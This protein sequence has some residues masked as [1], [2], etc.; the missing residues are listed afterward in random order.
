MSFIS[1][2]TKPSTAWLISNTL[3]LANYLYMASYPTK[4]LNIMFAGQP[5]IHKTLKLLMNCINDSNTTMPEKKLI[6]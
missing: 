4:K 6:Y 2:Q 5:F 1:N 3:P